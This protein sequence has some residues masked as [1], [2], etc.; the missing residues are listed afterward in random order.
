MVLTYVVEMPEVAINMTTTRIIIPQ[1]RPEI[2]SKVLRKPA[3]LE[4]D[5]GVVLGSKLVGSELVGSEL[6]ALLVSS[7]RYP[8]PLALPDIVRSSRGGNFINTQ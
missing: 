7:S 2:I 4:P 8:L 3:V 1:M 6:S 5:D